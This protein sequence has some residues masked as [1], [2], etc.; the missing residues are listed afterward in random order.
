MAD[1]LIH[2]L[3]GRT[4]LIRAGK[5]VGTGTLIAPGK[6]L[7]CAHV[8]RH[9]E[10][11]PEAIKVSLP[12]LTE[13]GQFIWEQGV[14]KLYL[15][16]IYEE[17]VAK[18]DVSGAPPATI[19]TEYPDVAVLEIDRKSHAM[20][21]L[22]FHEEGSNKLE[23]GEFLAFGFQKKDANLGRNVPQ[24]VSLN[25][26]GAQLD[27][28]IKKLMFA[29]GLIRPG[30]SGASLVERDTGEII[31]LIHMTM[32]AND[33][34]G[35]YA[36]PTET[37]WLVFK[38]WEEE[39]VNELYSQLTSK[40]LRR[41]IRKQYYKEYPRYPILKKYGIKLVILLVLLILAIWWFS[42]HIGQPQNSGVF[43]IILVA[44][45]IFGKLLGDWLG[46]DVRI[47]TERGKSRLGRW[48]LKT[49]VLVFAT[50]VIF[51]AWSFSTSIWIYGNADYNE[52]PIAIYTGQNFEEG[53][54]KTIDSTGNIRFFMPLI[55][56]GDSVKLVP[57][58]RE[59]KYVTLK[60]YFRKVLYYPKDFLL[61]PVILIRFAPKWLSVIQRFNI[62]IEIDKP[63]AQ[64]GEHKFVHIDSTLID[65]G[66]LVFGARRLEFNKA[67]EKEWEDYFQGNYPKNMLSGW[68]AKWKNAR[69][70]QDVDLDL[71]DN[72]TV[73]VTKKSDNTV[74]KEY[75]FS[76]VT[77]NTDELIR[78]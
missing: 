17:A 7:T 77:D 5:A 57:E 31:G 1:S 64:D 67:M 12:D 78:F 44:V 76:I 41:Q 55:F 72:V 59:P 29:N 19:K 40:Q 34:L 73:I 62:Q 14:Q 43:A 52:I 3:Q 68:V 45:S 13:P 9:F 53:Y 23:D 33:D 74:M 39:G 35:A 30:M 75:K 8:V 37:V 38:K 56:N 63:G 49:E 26:S 22:P 20:M 16:K 60:P 54:Q 28:S 36:I 58:G 48:L 51:L 46:K 11:Q 10:S 25:Y 32:S 50:T 6:V 70:F 15:S 61:E 65:E 21:A 24:A 47:E 18:P 2:F 69:R 71:G 66:S 42:Y 4:V 27:G